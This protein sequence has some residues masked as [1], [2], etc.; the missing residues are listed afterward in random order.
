MTTSPASPRS[1]HSIDPVESPKDAQDLRN[2]RRAN[3]RAR[4]RTEILDAAEQV[5]AEDG[6]PNGSIRKIAVRSGF[7]AAAIYLFF[8][9]KEQL[10]SETLS[11]RGDELIAVIRSVA[12]SNHE[13]LGKLHRVIDETVAFFRDR[14]TFRFLLRHLRGGEAI[15]GSVLGDFSDPTNNRFHEAM[16]LLTGIVEEGQAAGQVRVGDGWVLAHLYSVLINEFVLLDGDGARPARTFSS[17][18]FHSLV[19]AAFR[20]EG[21]E[22]GPAWIPEMKQGR[23]VLHQGNPTIAPPMGKELS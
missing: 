9:N 11:R 13:P 7:S 5:F 2:Q 16:A 8:E 22:P 15:T 14:P 21:P 10:V 17:E 20:S 18:Q 19:D 12:E 3:R 1:T 23:P 6:I 4:S